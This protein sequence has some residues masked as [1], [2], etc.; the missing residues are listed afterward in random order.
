[1][2]ERSE[3][4]LRNELLICVSDATLTSLRRAG[5]V[6]GTSNPGVYAGQLLARLFDQEADS[7]DAREIEVVESRLRDLGYL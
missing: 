6:S 2:T 1:M 3:N 5:E 7:M 4:D